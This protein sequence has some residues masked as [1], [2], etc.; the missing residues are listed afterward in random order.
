MVFRTHYAVKEGYRLQNKMGEDTTI[1]H[2][3]VSQII[4]LL[5]LQP[6]P[7]HVAV[8]FDS[9]GGRRDSVNGSGQVPHVMN[10]R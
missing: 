8:V 1:V 7:T 9:I 4:S 2:S 5:H 6:R 10:F 3:I